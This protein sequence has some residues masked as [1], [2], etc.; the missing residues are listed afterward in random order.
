MFKKLKNKIIFLSDKVRKYFALASMLFLLLIFV[1]FAERSNKEKLCTEIVVNFQSSGL[2]QFLTEREV[3]N[4]INDFNNESIIGYP[5]NQMNLNDMERILN[6]N[7][8]VESSQIYFDMNGVLY[9]IIKHR[10]PVLRVFSKDGGFYID[11]KGNKMQLS[12][13]YTSKVLVLTGNIDHEKLIDIKN[14]S[15]L[16]HFAK[17]IKDDVL[18]NSLIGQIH[19]TKNNELILIPRVGNLNIY[20]GNLQ[21]A[22]NKIER[23]KILY[24]KILP[25]EGWDKYSKA[26]VKFDKQI[27]LNKK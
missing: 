3:K 24:K 13:S 27:I 17:Y 8:Y 22:E 5:V 15:S 21:N 20:F 23:I 25:N 4:I 6:N 7:S 9:V 10:I 14:D 2:N 26:S 1:S 19:I 12:N 18:I 16:T 11:D